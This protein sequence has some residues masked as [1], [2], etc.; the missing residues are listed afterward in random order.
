MTLGPFV[1][2]NNPIYTFM[3]DKVLITFII[4]YFYRK[5]QMTDRK[6]IIHNALMND[7][8]ICR[9]LIHS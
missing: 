5:V 6:A 9:S 7:L 2:C 4:T 1:D 3:N 8:L